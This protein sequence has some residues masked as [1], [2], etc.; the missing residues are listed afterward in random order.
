MNDRCY[1]I[2][3][4]GGNFTTF[5]EAKKLVSLARDAGVD[6]VKLQTY[7]AD[8]IVTKTAIFDLD[9]VDRKSVV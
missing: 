8:T 6:A 1:V 7:R 2:A 5:E 3:E 9:N 4:I